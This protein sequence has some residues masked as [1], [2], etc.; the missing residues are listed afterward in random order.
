VAWDTTFD[1]AAAP[2]SLITF[3]RD[4]D[5]LSA[6]GAGHVTLRFEGRPRPVEADLPFTDLKVPAKPHKKRKRRAHR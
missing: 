1:V 6:T 4:G 3:R 2:D 5:R